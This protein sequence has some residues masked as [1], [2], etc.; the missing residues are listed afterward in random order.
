MKSDWS[1]DFFHQ[2]QTP[3]PY[4]PI[5]Q[6]QQQ[7]PHTSSS[8][9][10]TNHQLNSHYSSPIHQPP[11]SL[12]QPIPMMQNQFKASPPQSDQETAPT[13]PGSGSGGQMKGER[14][15][16]CGSESAIRVHY[17]ASSCHGCKAFFR[18]SVFEGRVYMCSADN[19]CDITNESRNRCRACRLRNCLEGGMNPKHVREE[20]SKIERM[21]G[22][23]CTVSAANGVSHSSSA[24]S[25]SPEHKFSFSLST[26]APSTSTGSFSSGSQPAPIESTNSSGSEAEVL[27]RKLIQENQLTLFMVA[28]EKQTEQLT[29]D[30]V[31]DNDVMGAWSRDITLTFGLQHPQMVI[32][33]LPLK[34]SCD[35][36]MEAAD[37]Y[38]SWYRSFVFAADWAMGIPEFRVLPL[39]DQTTLFKQNF[40]A[41]GW[42]TFAYKCFELKQ[43]LTGMPLGN[44]AYIP[45]N[46]EDQKKLPERW[47]QT[48]GVVCRKLIDLIVKA[49]IEL[50]ITEEEYCLIK[51]ISL[52]Q[53]DCI[54]SEAGQGICS[55]MR[56]RLLDA[57]SAHIEKRYPYHTTSQR[58]TRALKIS[59]MLPSFSHIGQV[60]STLIT[61]LT[62]ADLHQLSGVPMEICTA[63]TTL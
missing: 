54:L 21:P 37:L 23:T 19:H 15:V 34:Y 59:L 6:Q 20:R 1:T 5:V 3:N 50:Q 57:L 39:A 17:G 29:D 53:Q 49:M 43:H 60:E 14:C 10:N 7:P 31:K 12:H 27:D 25:A 16:G 58:M 11:T 46:D 51:T 56:D 35:R 32:K 47:A 45:Y 8:F 13:T 61:Q 2:S 36:I 44:G 18:R 52:F 48:Y 42:I 24:A 28:L 41:F 4:P 30:D 22:N 33:R 26:I 9:F 63:Q 40:M 62:A 55:R 38:L